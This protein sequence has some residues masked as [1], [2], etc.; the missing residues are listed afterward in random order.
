MV[1]SERDERNRG[2]G[3]GDGGIAKFSETFGRKEKRRRFC[4]TRRTKNGF[5]VLLAFLSF[6]SFFLFGSFTREPGTRP[7]FSIVHPRSSR[8]HNGETRDVIRQLGQLDIVYRLLKHIPLSASVVANNNT[9]S[10][11]ANSVTFKRE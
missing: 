9:R 2:H 1:V 8:S 3:R 6:F 4:A 10:A 5:N 7:L 11:A